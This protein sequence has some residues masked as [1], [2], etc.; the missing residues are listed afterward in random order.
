MLDG[1]VLS[2]SGLL[3]KKK[4]KKKKTG[5]NY[6]ILV[7]ITIEKGGT[8]E[9]NSYTCIIVCPPVRGDNPRAR[10]LSPVQADKLWL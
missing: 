9:R 2:K 6:W 4:K 1:V 5:A 10:G 3:F 7:V 8:H